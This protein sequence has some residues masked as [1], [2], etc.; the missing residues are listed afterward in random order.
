MRVEQ[1]DNHAV[2]EAALT[3]AW[4]GGTLSFLVLLILAKTSVREWG[5]ARARQ[6]ELS[7]RARAG[8][9][10]ELAGQTTALLPGERGVPA[11]RGDD[12]AGERGL[13]HR[14]VRQRGQQAPGLV[15]HLLGLQPS[16][17]TKLQ[18]TRPQPGERR[19]VLCRWNLHKIEGRSR[20]F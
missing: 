11:G 1:T 15:R 19:G 10:A 8:R 16:L 14:P 12:G 9:M 6:T 20:R 2:V 13:L 5:G 18:L 7:A 17:P 3:G 4:V